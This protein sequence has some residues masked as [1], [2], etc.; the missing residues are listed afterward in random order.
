MATMTERFGFTKPAG[1]DAGAVDV[2]NSNTD[3]TEL[4]LGRTQDMIAPLYDD[5]ATYDVDDIVTYESKLYKCITAISTAETFNPTKWEETTAVSEG[6]GGGGA[7][8]IEKTLSEYNALTPAQKENGSIYMVQGEGASEDAFDMTQGSSYNEGSMSFTATE[9]DIE[10]VWNGGGSIGGD[11]RTIAI[12][13]TDL[14]AIKFSI[15]TTTCYAHNNSNVEEQT[16]PRF[17]NTVYLFTSIP[18]GWAYDYESQATDFL[19]FAYTN[20]DYGEQEFD[21][22][23]LTGQIYVIWASTGWNAVMS[24]LTLVGKASLNNRIFFMGKEY[25]NTGGGTGAGAIEITSEDYEALSQAE[26]ENGTIYFVHDTAGTRTVTGTF[27]TGAEQYAKVE[28][29]CGLKPTKIDVVLPFSNG[30]TYASYDEDVSD[31]TSTWRIPMEGNTY[32]IILGSETGETGITDILD[33]GF[34][35]RCNAGN[36]RNVVCT[37]EATG[38]ASNEVTKIYYMGTEYS[39][40]G[41]GGSSEAEDINY[42]NTTSQLTATNVQEAIDEVVANAG[43]ASEDILT[44]QNVQGYDKYDET[45]TYAV[46][47]YAIYNKAQ[48]SHSTVPSGQLQVLSRLLME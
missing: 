42:D 39:T 16:T 32:T 27:I 3:L 4:Y 19:K 25:A 29:N 36:T 17:V 5:T 13:V 30:D 11:W 35:F 44:L 6:S 26:K 8:A 2:I 45:Q 15:E 47:D 23:E 46:G 7:S 40:G 22:S 34:K 21:V 28:V 33:N 9:T 48:Q 41:S 24:D 31:T 38:N 1:S 12:D 18:S 10:S 20:T 14:T 43:T 37:Y